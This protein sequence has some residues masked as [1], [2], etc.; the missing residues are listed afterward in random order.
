MENVLSIA[1]TCLYQLQEASRDIASYQER[2]EADPQRLQSTHSRLD[3]IDRLKKKYGSTVDEILGYQAQ[4]AEELGLL[5]NSEQRAEMLQTE[6]DQAFFVLS[7]HMV[8]LTA[9]RKDTAAHMVSAL[10]HELADLGMKQAVFD[11]AV[12]TAT[13]SARGQD[14]V[15]FMFSANP[16]EIPKP[17][18]KIISGGEMSRVMLALKTVLANVDRIATVIF[19]EIDTGIGGRAAQAVAEKMGQIALARQ[20]LCITHLPQIACMAD[21]HFVI[22]KQVQGE[23]TFTQVTPLD[24]AGQQ[25]ELA[26]MLG[27]ANLTDITLKHAAEILEMAE[28]Q[29][30]S[31][32]N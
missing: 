17:L 3:I 8:R 10:C 13:I 19:D 29:K 2:L 14:R 25:E 1:E 32:K 4:I 16:G 24:K 23:R 30:K 21:R 20:V 27:G 11:V 26:R 31:W 5:Q 7:E 15:E 22:C 28:Q 18:A 12:E 6:V 9:L